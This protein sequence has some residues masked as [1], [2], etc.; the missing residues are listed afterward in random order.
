MEMTGSVSVS[1][2]EKGWKS[3]RVFFLTPQVRFHESGF[4]SKTLELL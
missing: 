1:H 2:R 3:K 4:L